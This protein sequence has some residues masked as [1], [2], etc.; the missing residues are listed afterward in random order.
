M[1]FFSGS[2]KSPGGRFAFVWVFF[3]FFWGGAFFGFFFFFLREGVEFCLCVEGWVGWF[4]GGLFFLSF[5]S[6]FLMRKWMLLAGFFLPFPPP[7]PRFDGP[8]ALDGLLVSVGSFVSSFPIREG[9]EVIPGPL[10]FVALHSLQWR[11]S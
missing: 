8:S 1:S 9:Y 10:C 2:I 4:V 7:I 5:V 11:V 3:F 6:F